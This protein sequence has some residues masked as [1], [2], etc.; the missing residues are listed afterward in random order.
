MPALETP[1]Q[2]YHYR[3]KVNKSCE[4]AN[5][6]GFEVCRLTLMIAAIRLARSFDSAGGRMQAGARCV[7]YALLLVHAATGAGDLDQG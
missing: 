7:C 4:T 2:N 5:I 6:K 3:D 1:C